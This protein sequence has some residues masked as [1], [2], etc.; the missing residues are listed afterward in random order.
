MTINPVEQGAEDLKDA[1]LG[2]AGTVL[3]YAAGLAA[4]TVGWRW[5]RGFLGGGIAPSAGPNYNNA[6]EDR[7]W[8]E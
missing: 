7:A 6:D 5:V 3:P 1:L 8:E 2:I 4:I